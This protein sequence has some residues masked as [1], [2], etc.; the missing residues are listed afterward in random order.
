M[1]RNRY[2]FKGGKRYSTDETPEQIVKHLKRQLRSRRRSVDRAKL[3]YLTAICADML[4]QYD[5]ARRY[6][7]EVIDRY[8]D[9]PFAERARQRLPH[10]PARSSAAES[11]K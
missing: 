11:G 8:G 9:T 4:G 10:V 5:Q 1:L 7:E 2:Y 3:E 6:Y